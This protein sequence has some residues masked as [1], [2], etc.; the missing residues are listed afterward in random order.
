MAVPQLRSCAFLALLALGSSLTLDDRAFGQSLGLAGRQE[1]QMVPSQDILAR[2]SSAIQKKMDLI[3]TALTRMQ[4]DNGEIAPVEAK[5]VQATK[6]QTQATSNLR[7]P[8]SMVQNQLQASAGAK[9]KSHWS[10]QGDWE[11]F[12]WDLGHG[13]PAQPV[14]RNKVVLAVIEMVPPLGV[15]GMD[16]L[17]LGQPVRAFIKAASFVGTFG[18][19]GTIWSLCDAFVIGSN[20]VLESRRLDQFGMHVEFGNDQGRLK[21]SAGLGLLIFLIWWVHIVW[22]SWYVYKNIQPGGRFYE[23]WLYVIGL[24]DKLLQQRREHTQRYVNPARDPFLTALEQPHG[25]CLKTDPFLSRLPPPKG[26]LP[27]EEEIDAV[28]LDTVAAAPVLSPAAKETAR[29]AEMHGEETSLGR[30][31]RTARDMNSVN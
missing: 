31:Y 18:V 5:I 2:E 9:S 8:V 10:L 22:F 16:R 17:Y 29:K 15:L 28:T 1:A 30:Y 13:G 19:V 20:C 23:Q 4:H 24:Q 6:V 26:A 21:L 14:R 27:E 12:R 25:H 3:D 7:K 11:E